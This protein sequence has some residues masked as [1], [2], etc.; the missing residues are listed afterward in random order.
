MRQV[1]DFPTVCHATIAKALDVW[2]EVPLVIIAPEFDRGGPLEAVRKDFGKQVSIFYGFDAS[3]LERMITATKACSEDALIVRIDALHFSWIPE[4][5]NSMLALAQSDNLDCVKMPDDFPIQFTV[6]VYRVGALR[7]A[8][9]RLEQ[10]LEKAIYSVHVKYYMLYNSS[11]KSAYYDDYETVPNSYLR[12]CRNLTGSIYSSHVDVLLEKQFVTGNQFPFRYELACSYISESD[13]VLD[14]ACSTGWG[15]KILAEKAHY[16]IGADLD[17]KAVAK[18]RLTACK[19]ITFQVEDCL[20]MSF[21]DE[22]FD[23]VVSCET[24]EHVDAEMF[25]QEVKRVLKPSGLLLMTTPQNRLGHIPV[26]SEH[27]HEFSAGELRALCKEHFRVVKM[28]GIKQ[29]RIVRE[30]DELGTG[31]FIVCQ[32]KTNAR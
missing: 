20:A 9:E 13:T 4:H 29:G 32:K 28:I 30:D 27:L 16:V 2:P 1:G 23:V 10:E 26:T 7:R 3:P 17:E 24:I 15:A 14:I 19:N 11:F 21:A 12:Q 6:D 22:T 5:A 31:S 18:A 8:R 25:L